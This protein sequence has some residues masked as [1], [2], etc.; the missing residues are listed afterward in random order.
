MYTII[1]LFTFFSVFSAFTQQTHKCIQ[2]I[3]HKIISLVL[4]MKYG[5]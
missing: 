2:L 5:I 1:H 3:V 4:D